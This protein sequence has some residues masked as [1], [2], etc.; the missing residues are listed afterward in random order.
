MRVVFS[1]PDKIKNKKICSRVNTRREKPEERGVMHCHKYVS[2]CSGVVYEVSFT[3]EKVYM[4]Q[5]GRRINERLREH[6]LSLNSLP[7]GASRF[8]CEGLWVRPGA[9]QL[10]YL[11]RSQNKRAYVIFEAEDI[12]NKGY[13]IIASAVTSSGK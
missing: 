10:R 3:S 6:A 9:V 5:S 2:C 4:G 8:I 11:R 12:A 1:A 7:I 13:C